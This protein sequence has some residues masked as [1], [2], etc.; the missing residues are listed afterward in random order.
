MSEAGIGS[1][2]PRIEPRIFKGLRDILPPRMRVRRFVVEC[3]RGVFESYGFE[4]LETPAIEFHDILTGKSGAEADKLLFPLAYEDGRTLALRYD[5]TVPLS[6]VVAM[7]GPQ[8][9]FPFKR[10]QMQPVWRAE[11]PQKGRY[12]EFLQC[13]VDTVG[14]DSMAADAEILGLACDAMRR[15]GFARFRLELNDRKLV[16][17]LY[18]A[19]GIPPEIHT[20]VSRTVDKLDKIGRDEVR[21]VLVEGAEGPAVPADKASA[22][23]ELL[24]TS[25][26]DR[27]EAATGSTAAGREG[28]AEI[29]EILGLLSAIPAASGAVVYS[30]ALMRGLDYYTGP[31]FEA[32]VDEPKI[33]SL[34]GGGR[35]DGL[36]AVFSGESRPAVGFSFG[37]ERLVDAMEERGQGLIGA[38]AARG[39][40]VLVTVFSPAL[41]KEST[42]LAAELRAAGLRAEVFLEAGKKLG[43]QFDYANR[44]AV[45]VAATIGPEEAAG[46]KVA[47]KDMAK[48]AQEKVAR[49]EAPARVR[50]ILGL[51]TP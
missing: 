4:P 5:L 42:A 38:A 18:E 27:I 15:L 35:Y 11:K 39:L 41:R 7:N 44:K 48:G 25:D 29:R 21:R 14:T 46:G 30:P 43:K 31:V 9:V 10:Y 26:L 12:R 45:P 49:A 23:L 8:M 50:E 13:D 51:P 6:R 47:L 32:V 1:G 28:A 20:F 3:L 19:L 40:D 34:G 24:E 22:L 2:K 33:G 36:I 16:N 17:G 37:V